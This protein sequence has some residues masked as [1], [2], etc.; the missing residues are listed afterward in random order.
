MQI[1]GT[2]LVKGLFDGQP[3]DASQFKSKQPKHLVGGTGPNHR[4]G[5]YEAGAAPSAPSAPTAPAP[6]PPPVPPARS[7]NVGAANDGASRGSLEGRVKAV[8]DAHNLAGL[9][10]DVL[11]GAARKNPHVA[12]NVEHIG[13][14]AHHLRN[15]EGGGPILT[16]HVAEALEYGGCEGGLDA[17]VTELK[18]REAQTN[19]ERN[20]IGMDS[21]SH[22]RARR[23]GQVQAAMQQ[24]RQFPPPTVAPTVAPASAVAPPKPH[25]QMSASEFE[26]HVRDNPDVIRWDGHA[27]YTHTNHAGLKVSVAGPRQS[28][29][30]FAHIRA[31]G[32]ALTQNKGVPD[33]VVAT[34]PYRAEI[35]LGNEDKVRVATAR[36]QAALGQSADSGDAAFGE[37]AADM[38][39]PYARP[40]VKRGAMLYESS[41]S[42]TIPAMGQGSLAKA[43]ARSVD[44]GASKSQPGVSPLMQINGTVLVKGLFDSKPLE[45]S[46][47]QSKTPKHLLGGRGPNHKGGHYALGARVAAALAR[48]DGCPAQKVIDFNPLEMT[49]EERKRSKRI[50]DGWTREEAAQ[51]YE[52]LP[53]ETQAEFSRAR[54]AYLDSVEALGPT[55]PKETKISEAWR[56][57]HGQS[58]GDAVLPVTP[59]AVMPSPQGSLFKAH[60]TG[61]PLQ[62]KR[63]FRGLDISIEHR[64]GRVR[65]G[66]DKDG[67]PW[68]VKMKFPYGYILKS[69]GVDGDHFDCFV[70]PN[71]TAPN[72]YVVNALDAKSGRFDEQKAMLGFASGK[73][74]KAA[75]L[76]SYSSPRFFGSMK[77]MPYD[78]F[79]RKVLATLPRARKMGNKRGGLV[80]S[81]PSRVQQKE[82]DAETARINLNKQ[83]PNAK[84]S[85]RFK[86]A[87]WTHPNGHPRCLICGSEEPVGGRCKMSASWYK[88]QNR[89][90]EKSIAVAKFHSGLKRAIGQDDAPLTK[91]VTDAIRGPLRRAGKFVPGEDCPHC[92][93]ELEQGS[94]KGKMICNRCNKPWPNGTLATADKGDGDGGLTW[95]CPWCG[96]DNVSDSPER[97]RKCYKCALPVDVMEPM[98]PGKKNG[99]PRDC[100]EVTPAKLTPSQS[101]KAL[102]VL[103]KSKRG[104]SKRDDTMQK[105]IV[106]SLF[107]GAA[108]SGDDFKSSCANSSALKG[109]KR[110]GG[111]GPAHKGS[112][113]DGASGDLFSG[114]NPP[115]PQIA[116]PRPRANR[117]MSKPIPAVPSGPS[118]FALSAA[119]A[120]YGQQVALSQQQH[121]LAQNHHR[122]EEPTTAGAPIQ[123]SEMHIAE[124]AEAREPTGQAPTNSA[125]PLKSARV[126]GAAHTAFVAT[127]SGD[128][129]KVASYVGGKKTLR[130]YVFDARTFPRH[131]ADA[132]NHAEQAM[133]EAEGHLIEAGGDYGGPRR[134]S[135]AMAR[136]VAQVVGN[137]EKRRGDDKPQRVFAE[138]PAPPSQPTLPGDPRAPRQ[139]SLFKSSSRGR[140]SGTVIVKNLFDGQPLQ[141]SEFK[142]KKPRHLVGGTG[143]AHQG[144]H[145][146]P[147]AP[148]TSPPP[149]SAPPVAAPHLPKNGGRSIAELEATPYVQDQMANSYGSA[150]AALPWQSQEKNHQEDVYH[151]VH[152]GAPGESGV[153]P[154]LYLGKDQNALQ[155]FYDIDEEG[156]KVSSFKGKPNWLDLTDKDDFDRFEAHAKATHGDLPDN[157]HLRL[158][159]LQHG[160]DGI[161][162]HDTSATGEEFVLYNTDKLKKHQTLS[163][164]L[165]LRGKV[166]AKGLFD[167]QPLQASQFKSKQPK[168]LVGGQGSSHRGAKRVS[169]AAI[170]PPVSVNT[171]ATGAPNLFTPPAAPKSAAPKAEVPKAEA[172]PTKSDEALNPVLKWAGGK[173]WLLPA[174]RDLYEPHAHR[175]LVDPFAGGLSV[176]LGA[177]AKNVLAGDISPHLIN[178]YR[179]LQKGYTP[180]FPDE[181]THEEFLKRRARFNDIIEAGKT[182]T[183]EAAQLFHYLNRSCF[184]GLCRF[185]RKGLFNV[186]YNKKDGVMLR[187]IK[188]LPVAHQ[189]DVDY[190]GYQGALEGVQFH[191]GSYDTIPAKD[192]DFIYSDPPYDTPFAAY[193]KE[194]FNW[195]D[196]VK[197]AQWLAQHPGPAVTSNE[198]T[199]RI[200]DL[201]KGLGFD[202]HIVEAPR[203]VSVTGDRTP[204]KEMI[205]T[206]NIDPKHVKRVVAKYLKSST[207]MAPAPKKSAKKAGG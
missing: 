202:V 185:N 65:S 174:L 93:A 191:H 108:L 67:T 136:A 205:A 109:K 150:E 181:N 34:H 33:S 40:R 99:K 182:D 53:G 166:I 148:V 59:R 186:G 199:P 19:R 139:E 96:V 134:N 70:G 142:S 44:E 77:A 2:V 12:R 117:P 177:G 144:G 107:D 90:A 11:L 54:D 130:S 18:N 17:K 192:D 189:N 36:Y 159:T 140:L 196:Q 80:K 126:K 32:H 155:Q 152:G 124:A 23:A 175:R 197:H 201:Y 122:T 102:N 35:A 200:I 21:I 55:F 167:G 22:F 79:E 116:T 76:A 128:T 171:S 168:H 74:A 61:Y 66:I 56:I 29:I 170:A 28:A 75:F 42:P 52:Q 187:K 15:Q 26:Q 25:Y 206:R 37:A 165:S 125:M 5:R 113:W 119:D 173:R 64:K 47:F 68:R 195:D 81:V 137:G 129:I 105:A 9:S 194:G 1:N 14:I 7:S 31:I 84:K 111:S 176:T 104:V 3:L 163:K 153:G 157:A 161:R 172:G 98:N 82:I 58:Y 24:A 138:P 179:R 30:R 143:P 121:D 204:A 127:R 86:P 110:V 49:E 178:L 133:Y 89:Q 132:A 207:E 145:Y 100:W 183:N 103:A 4:G 92:G 97:D 51:D 188:G 39:S 88:E 147:G 62:G 20:A 106:K 120:L 45:A 198:A 94:C 46:Q 95:P 151:H 193:S 114:N 73:A 131:P 101:A 169:G 149:M 160:Y 156:K 60:A 118:N 72:V 6:V 13:A 57:L 184:N 69:Q 164:N 8:A 203:K 38:E 190:S 146:E 123:V 10:H 85:H 141:A 83:K 71:E 115:S 27:G 158:H 41:A 50:I 16:A 48:T 91:S 154:G 162:Y 112:H 135:E 43:R 78:E 63:K 180:N 87:K